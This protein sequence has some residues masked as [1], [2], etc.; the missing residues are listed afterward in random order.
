[1]LKVTN[2]ITVEEQ[3]SSFLS[4]QLQNTDTEV[5]T[6]GCKGHDIDT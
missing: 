3:P 1:M 5:H 6:V 2:Q 4:L